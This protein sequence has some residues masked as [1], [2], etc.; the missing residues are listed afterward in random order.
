M[1]EFYA[2]IKPIKDNFLSTATEED[3]K[4]MGEHFQYLKKLFDRGKLILAGPVIDPEDTKG[5]YI[6]RVE[7]EEEGRKIMAEDPAIIK[8]VQRLD[9]FRPFRASLYVG[10]KEE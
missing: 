2:V 5:I 10:K 8:G 7:S 4:I 3:N 1:L 9:E 6:I